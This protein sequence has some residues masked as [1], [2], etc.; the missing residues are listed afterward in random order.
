MRLD[1]PLHTLETVH[2]ASPTSTP[3]LH[4]LPILFTNTFNTEIKEWRHKLKGGSTGFAGNTT[5][6][7]PSST[8]RDYE[9][10]CLQSSDPIPPV[11]PLHKD[12]FIRRSE[13]LAAKHALETHKLQVEE[14]SILMAHAVLP[15]AD[16][17]L[18]SRPGDP[19]TPDTW[20]EAMAC[21]DKAKWLQAAHKELKNHLSNGTWR[22]IDRE[23]NKKPLT[24]RW[25]FRVKDD[26]TYKARL[27]V[28]GFQ[29]VPGRDFLDV[30]A[31]FQLTDN[32]VVKRFLA[33]D[34]VRLAGD[35]YLSQEAYIDKILSRFT[36]SSV[37][38]VPTPF[39][40]KEVLPPYDSSAQATPQMVQLYQEQVGSLVW[41]VVST[42]PDVSWA[43]CKLAKY[44]HNPASLHFQAVKRVFRYLKGS[45]RL[46]LHFSPHPAVGLALFAYVDAS[47]A[48]PHDDNRLSTTGYVFMLAGAAIIWQSKRQTL[49][50]L[51]STEAEYVAACLCCQDLSWIQLMLAE[52]GHQAL[53]PRP[54]VIHEDNQG[55]IALASSDKF[56]TRSK[57]IDVKYHY[58]REKTASNDCLFQYVPTAEQAADGLTK[59]LASTLF[60]RFVKQ[61]G[62]YAVPQPT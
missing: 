53:V 51:S 7:L 44:S 57:H 6:S 31:H 25:V 60:Q 10:V 9:K 26:G 16:E 2:P 8:L 12:V 14:S 29:Q 23:R 49:V 27:V 4:Q 28:R 54:T 18:P 55:T 58:V 37:K 5:Y 36:F 22:I 33:I 24:L 40:E 11:I 35:V 62:L 15:A 30:Y 43:V 47:W 39:N 19:F 45:K 41:V 13:R 17:T 59:P 46:C 56:T 61:L 1:I 38:P 52:L 34:I 3:T 21:P 42:R 50:T 32:G 20:T 48:S